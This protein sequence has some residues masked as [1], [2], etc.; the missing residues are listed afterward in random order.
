MKLTFPH[1]DFSTSAA[2]KDFTQCL[3]DIV[4]GHGCNDFEPYC[5]NE[6]D[7]TFWTLDCGNDWNVIFLLDEPS[8]FVIR[9]RYQCAAN[10]FEEALAGWLAVRIGATI[11]K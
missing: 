5:P 1:A 7:D 4:E 2:R 3:S 8:V 6:H 11:V 9:Y 10:P